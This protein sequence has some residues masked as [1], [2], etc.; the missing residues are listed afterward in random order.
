MPLELR[1]RSATERFELVPYDPPPL[2]PRQI[3]GRT[4][5]AAPKHGTEMR[6]WHQNAFRGRRW[7]ARLRLFLDPGDT[8]PPAPPES[9]AVGNMG[10]VTVT[11]VGAEVA[12]FRPGDLV[13]GYMPVREIQTLDAGGLRPLGTVSPEDAVCIDPAHV[14]FIAVRDGN[15]RLGD[16]VAVFG[17]GA[18][19]LMTVQAARASGARRVIAVDPLASRRA[20]ATSLG[21]DLTLDPAVGDTALAIKQATDLDGVDVALE[22]SGADPAV[23]EAIRCIRQCGT[24]VGVGW[25]KTDGRG[26]YLGEEFHINRPTLVASQHSEYWGNPSR[27]HPLWSPGRARTACHELFAAG[28]LTSRQVLDPIVPLQQAPDVLQA[29]LHDPGSVLKVGVRMA[30]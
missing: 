13:Y 27:D 30:T 19:G 15:V 25:S 11:E 29:V 21:A 4:V 6:S 14:A 26:L 7:D 8:P 1:F 20:R 17:L 12:D 24:V 18:I 2:G 16:D 22:I 28:R 5:L 10:V 23:R 9:V 3:R